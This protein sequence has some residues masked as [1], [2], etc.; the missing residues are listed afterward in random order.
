MCVHQSKLALI[1]LLLLCACEGT[2][3][4]GGSLRVDA[5][6]VDAACEPVPGTFPSGLGFLPGS[7]DQVAAVELQPPALTIFDLG[8]PAPVQRSRVPLP[9]LDMDADG[10]RDAL[11]GMDLLDHCCRLPPILGTLDTDGDDTLLVSTSGYE[12]VLTADAASGTLLLVQV[13][14]PASARAGDHPLLP[15]PGGAALRTAVS[16]FA[17]AYPPVPFDSA[18]AALGPHPRCDPGRPGF[19]TSF[20][21]GKAVAGGHLFVATSNLARSDPPIFRPGTVLVFEWDDTGATP[22]ARPSPTTRMLFTSGFNPTGVARHVT[23]AGRELVLVTATGAIGAATG[24]E[25]I[26]TEA[27]LDVIDVASLRVVASIPLGFAGP[28]FEPVALHPGGGLALLG[29]SSQRQLFAVDLRPLDDPDLYLP[30]PGPVLLDGLTPGFPNARIAGA[31]DP[32]VLPDRLDG[33]PA[34]LCAGLTEAR[35]DHS[36]STAWAIDECDGTLTRMTIDLSG[37]P[38]IPLPR[39]RIQVLEQSEPFAPTD[40]V[41]LTRSPG[42]LRVRPG[43]PGLDY[44]GPEMVLTSGEPAG[45]CALAVE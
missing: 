21:A 45:V 38:P 40:A 14:T 34:F 18:G 26:R 35:F 31:D 19:L 29:S 32:I 30:R 42:N 41:G 37:N 3:S 39:A 9:S 12:Q 36:G 17:C 24:P 10:E 4:S 8:G 28:S 5:S 1:F 22:V 11:V 25:N 23:P 44:T 6:R 13:E 43:R 7:A 20:T 27:F 16:T 2:G 15:P 33:P